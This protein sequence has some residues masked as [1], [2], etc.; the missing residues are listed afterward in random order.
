[1]RTLGKEEK[2]PEKEYYMTSYRTTVDRGRELSELSE[3]VGVSINA[4]MDRFIGWA[5]EDVQ[6]GKIKLSKKEPK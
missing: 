3:R 1:M 4:I 2:P 5:L 6:K